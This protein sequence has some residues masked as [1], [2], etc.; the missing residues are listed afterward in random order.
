MAGEGTSAQAKEQNYCAVPSPRTWTIYAAG[1]RQ[2]GDLG[3]ISLA[4][5]YAGR[6]FRYAHH[7]LVSI[8]LPVGHEAENLRVVSY[9]RRL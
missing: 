9:L 5:H 8:N 4:P 6:D 3:L 7:R 2:P 1:A